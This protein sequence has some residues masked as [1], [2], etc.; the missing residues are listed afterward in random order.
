M[1]EE[2]YEETDQ[3]SN[4][5]KEVIKEEIKKQPYWHILTFF[6]TYLGS[7]FVPSIIF[8][9]YALFFLYPYVLQTKSIISL[10]TEPLSLITFIA[11]PIV[12]VV[13]YLTHLFFVALIVRFWWNLSEKLQ[14][15]KNGVIPRN[16]P[17][18]ILN[19]YH[20]RSFM[21]KY[22]KNAFSKGPLPWLI[23]WMYN[24]VGSNKIGKGSTMEEQVCGDRFIQIGEN[25]YI[26]PNSITTSHMVDGTFGNISYFKVKIGDNVTMAASNA[27]SPG[28][29]I[30]D[31]AYLLPLA[32]ASKF[33]A[34]KG[35]NY[36]YGIPLRR[37]FKR[38]TMEYLQITKEDLERDDE[39][40]NKFA[41]LKKDLMKNEGIK[42][43]D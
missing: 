11:F 12:V 15:S 23:R 9:L 16:I 17:S 36:Y 29:E 28:C 32:S 3:N 19:F 37:I 6:T 30:N 1:L 35:D 24:F 21:I 38:K 2:N 31:N 7:F 18:R 39:L 42:E 8:F 22:P 33:N 26:G 13:C 40:K 43:T 20:I 27:I 25:S 34:V 5:T 4:G 10:F 41:S 14:P